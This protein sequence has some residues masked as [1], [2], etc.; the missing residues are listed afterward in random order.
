MPIEIQ[1]LNYRYPKSK[2]ETLKNVNLI[3]E[4]GEINTILGPNGSGKTTLIKILTSQ[5]KKQGE[6]RMEGKDIKEIPYAEKQKMISYLP[7]ENGKL[8]NLTVFEVVLLGN[9]SNLSLKPSQE[10]LRHTKEMLDKFDLTDIENKHYD[11]LSGGQRRIVSICQ[12]LSKNPK[13]LILDEPTANLDVYN[14]IEVLEFIQNYVKENRIYCLMV[15]HSINLA[16]RYS[17][18]I[19]LL[20]SGSIYKSGPPKEI[21]TEE[22][23]KEVY[24]IIVERTFTKEGKPL[25]HI[26]GNDR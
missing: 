10:I 26:L 20:K 23:L 12:A 8:T 15:L 2:E 18:K 14:E 24:R 11:E 5:L 1:N 25:I 6:I 4:K 19:A 9:I 21:I 13:L 17:D 7:Q 3:L 16:S 22:N